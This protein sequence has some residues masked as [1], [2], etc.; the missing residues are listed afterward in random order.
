MSATVLERVLEQPKNEQP[1]N[2]ELIPA[3]PAPQAAKT[4]QAAAMPQADEAP[5][6]AFSDPHP[7]LPV[8]VAGAIS[9]A[10]SSGFVG[11][12]L[13]WLAV[14]DSGIMSVIQ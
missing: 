7:L 8:F 11:A 3:G 12:I 5:Q 2:L 13:I 10:L 4:P 14:R 9:L 6:T 1:R